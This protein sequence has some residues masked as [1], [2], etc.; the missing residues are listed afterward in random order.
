MAKISLA[1]KSEGPS[2]VSPTSSEP[3]FPSFYLDGDAAEPFMGAKLGAEQEVKVKLRLRSK[4][5]NLT[6][7]ASVAFD[8]L[9]MDDGQGKSDG[10][11]AETIFG[12]K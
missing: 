9:D 10:E 1:Q 3:S 5:E 2:A 11:K 8:M 6:G 7:R 12:K 4:S